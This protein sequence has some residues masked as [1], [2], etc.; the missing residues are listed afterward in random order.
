MNMKTYVLGFLIAAQ[1]MPG[2][3]LAQTIDYSQY[4]S[5][6]ELITQL[7]EKVKA[8]QSKLDRQLAVA[9]REVQKLEKEKRLEAKEQAEIKESLEN[10]LVSVNTRLNMYE[11]LLRVNKNLNCSTT[12]KPIWDGKKAKFTSYDLDKMSY[13][14]EASASSTVSNLSSV[15]RC[16]ES[17]LSRYA[18]F[19][20]AKVRIEKQLGLDTTQVRP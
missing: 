17:N 14:E 6:Q 7:L 8:L 3:S 10:S 2:I 11:T 1:L 13:S 4:I 16:N 5:R 20:S 19:K 12:I 15:I 9:E 18:G